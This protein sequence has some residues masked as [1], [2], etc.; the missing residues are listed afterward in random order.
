MRGPFFPKLA[1][2]GIKKNGQVYYPYLLTC[3]VMVMM[4]YIMHS[5]GRSPLLREFKGGGSV[6]VCLGLAKFVIAIFAVLFLLYTNS[7]LNKRRNKEFGL[8]HVLGMGK[9]GLRRIV[10]WESF[11]A[12]VIGLGGG[13]LCGLLFSKLAELLLANIV[14]YEIDFVYRVDFL[15]IRFTVEMFGAI[16][17]ILTESHI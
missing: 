10:L 13:L 14:H 1:L 5:L 11:F 15:A 17:L 2:S 16:F 3:I 6:E 9:K 4:F 7:F 8:Y 12:A